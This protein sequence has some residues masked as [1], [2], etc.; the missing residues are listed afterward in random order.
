[1]AA[2]PTPLRGDPRDLEA[3]LGHEFR[4]RPLLLQALAHKSYFSVK[5]STVNDEPAPARDNELL[6]FLGDAILE[7]LTREHLVT[8]HPDSTEGDLSQRKAQ[9]VSAKH[10]HVVAQRIGL[11]RYLLLSP[12]EER[13]GGRERQAVLADALEALIGALYLDGGLPV[14]RQFVETHVLAGA[15]AAVPRLRDHKTALQERCQAL[16]LPPP[17]YVTLRQDGPEH[18]KT[19]VVE[20][21]LGEHWVSEGQGPSKKQA[22]QEAARL[23]L[24]ELESAG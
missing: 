19:F 5:H 9:L 12:G 7:L 22:E 17:R 1:M 21:R 10:L 4:E 20:V 8:R 3:F 2:D 11:G 6:E 16:K 23:L 15:D 13:T 24:S 14:A 18:R